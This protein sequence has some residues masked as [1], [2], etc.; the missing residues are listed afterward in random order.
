MSDVTQ[1]LQRIESG[2][3]K[4]AAEL[5]PLVYNELRRL[6]NWQMAGEKPGQT[7]QATAL[8]HEAFVK[9]V[10]SEH[11]CNYSGRTPFF[12]AAADAMRHILVD[13]ARQKMAQ[14]RGGGFA[15]QDVDI[16]GIQ[17]DKPTELLKVNDALDALANHNPKAAQ[18]VNLHYFGGFSLAEIAEI[19]G[20]SRA[21]VNRWWTYAKAW[22]R[23]AIEDSV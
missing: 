14:K 22:L 11:S 7:L 12:N 5:F 9:L 4:A 19:L 23:T 1:L 18:V 8:V 16:S 20:V 15:R 2:D 21:T 3:S 10:G 6:A 13:V 17:V